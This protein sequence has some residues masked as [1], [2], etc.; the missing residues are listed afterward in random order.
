MTEAEI[1]APQ[2]PAEPKT[3]NQSI[4]KEI[5]EYVQNNKLDAFKRF[6]SSCLLIFSVVIIMGLIGSKQ[7]NLSSRSSPA[8][9]YILI[10]AAV[11]WLTMVEGSQGSL[12]GLSPV[13]PELYKDSHPIAY[14]CNKVT[15][16]GDNLDRYLMG[17]Q[18]MVCFIVFII[19]MSGGPAGEVE[20]WGMSKAAKDIFFNVGLA[21]IFF[22]AMI[23][24]LNSQVNASLCMLDYCNNYFCV[25]TMWVAL[26]IEYS[27]LLHSSYLIQIAVVKCAGQQLMSNED[28][29]TAAQNAFFW[30][31]CMM[32]LAIVS[33]CGVVTVYAL[34]TDQ[35]TIWDGIPPII[36]LIIFIILLSIVGML[37]GM[38]I[39][40]F[41]VAKLLPSERGN[42]IFARKTC[43]LLFKGT[44]NNL[45]GFMIG[46]QLSV[47]SCMF[48]VAR[49]TSVSIKEGG[50]NLFGVSDGVQALFNTGLL[51]ALFLTIVGSIAWQLVASAFPLAFLANPLTY[52]FLRICLFF[53]M[54][55]ICS[56]AWVLAA[57]HS[58]IVGFQRDEVYIGTA[59]ERAKKN[60]GDDFSHVPVGPGRLTKLPAYV[61]HA[62]VA[63]QELM[64]I[65]DNVAEFVRQLSMHAGDVENNLNNSVATTNVESVEGNNNDDKKPAESS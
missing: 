36:A 30:F 18:L 4:T 25:F 14:M 52:V 51:G 41:A 50:E 57:I 13:N 8:A 20:L 59:E 17:R 42:S 62:P 60:M 9:A 26:A 21:M 3:N 15:I 45:P 37:E 46:R 48:F 32:S 47:V 27:G 28:P 33:F 64:K 55:G 19:N 11:I 31:R 35:T 23:G 53:E 56:G 61:E 39:A 16:K 40:F 2:A 54:T 43:S 49:V 6:Y 22:T 63:L 5:S 44:G 24:Q 7:T 38:Q 29:R 10:W 65:D 1:N 58:K 12:V 34:F